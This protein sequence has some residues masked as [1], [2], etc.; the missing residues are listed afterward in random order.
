ML[1]MTM[2]TM[3]MIILTMM[4]IL[5]LSAWNKRHIQ[6]KYFKAGNQHQNFRV[7]F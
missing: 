3:T 7:S 6:S 1:T 4:M 5:A 2:M